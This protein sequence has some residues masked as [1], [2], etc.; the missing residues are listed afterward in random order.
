[1]TAYVIADVTITNAQAYEEYR[2]H[3]SDSLTPY[4]G[5]FI[6]RGGQYETLEGDWAPGRIVVIEFPDMD[7]LKAWYASPGYQRIISLRHRSSTGR[8][9]AIQ[10]A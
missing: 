2:R 8:L 6:V 7:K 1:M 10:G 3:T 9:I 5:R 4:G